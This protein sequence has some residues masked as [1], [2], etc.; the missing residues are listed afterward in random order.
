M[1]SRGKL[2]GN[3]LYFRVHGIEELKAAFR[4]YRGEAEK[5]LRALSRQTAVD[6][7]RAARIKA[8][9]ATGALR[10]AIRMSTRPKG[11]WSQVSQAIPYAA[12]QE[13]GTRY[14]DPADYLRSEV[15]A[16]RA[17]FHARARRILFDEAVL[18]AKGGGT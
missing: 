6:I 13:L 11:A 14:I 4:R 15:R 7:R 5:R 16:R 10:R 18:V 12:H 17:R 8:P 1:T 9:M 2:Y 3:T